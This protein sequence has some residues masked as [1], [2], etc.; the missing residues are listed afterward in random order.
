MRRNLLAVSVLAAC[1]TITL[2]AQQS[3]AQQSPAQTPSSVTGNPTFSSETTFVQVP[4]IVQRSKKHVSGLKKEDFVLKQDGKEQPI[5]SFEE[6]HNGVTRGEPAT[7]VGE[8]GLVQRPA[9]QQ[10]AIIGIDMVNT[11][12]LDRAYFI[13]QFVHYLQRTPKMS[14]PTA[15]VAIERGG[16][17]VIREFTT[18]PKTL[19]AGMQ[20]NSNS[21]TR[22]NN[23][24]SKVTSDVS[25]E[26]ISGAENRG[27]SEVPLWQALKIRSADENMMRFQDKSARVDTQL[28]VQQL[29]QALKGLPGRKSLILVGS[30]FKFI[31]SNI[32]M[33]SI[34]GGAGGTDLVYSVE[35][36]GESTGQA[37]YTWKLL[38]DANVAVYPIDTRRTVN[39]AF[40]SMDVSGGNTPNSLSYEQNRQADKDILD[41]FRLVAAAT[42]GNA[43]FYRTDLDECL[44]EAV[45]DDH[46]YY[47]L[48]FYAD[49]KN[50][51]TGWHKVE[52]KL[53][54]KERTSVRSRQGFIIAK[55]NGESARKNDLGLALNS[56]F[57]YTELPFNY[58]F[59]APDPLLKKTADSD[60]SKQPIRFHIFIPPG[61]LQ[62]DEAAGKVDFDM[63][64][65]ARSDGGKQVGQ[66]IKRV[67]R[68]FKPEQI[69]SIKHDGIDYKDTI[70]V[71]S[72]DFG[73]WFVIRD[74]I[75]QRT[76]SAVA[77]LKVP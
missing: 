49:K 40:Q 28:A 41:T 59:D 6:V 45:E 44:R 13:E 37:A 20:A 10:I 68:Q 31:D 42:G 1:A 2:N 38:N 63:V 54:T 46:D 75:G 24:L 16:I 56:P 62:V 51:Q 72:G 61:A 57:S 14:G 32:V 15:L 55:F 67:A 65:I 70:D 39:T 58:G 8:Q 60:P 53:N 36:V 77:R 11:P 3:G 43:C 12:N 22:S 34:A 50:H 29:A 21:A 30:G 19:L 64:A 73:V 74:N 26:A 52:V 66:F 71:P 5:A 4:V 9:P 48:G 23:D 76:G 69:A 27:A 47:M 7:V 35:N 17:K 18:D 33:K 25:D